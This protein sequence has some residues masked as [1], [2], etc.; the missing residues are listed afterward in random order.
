MKNRTWVMAVALAMAGTQGNCLA[1]SSHAWDD[2]ALPV[3]QR[4]AQLVDAMT[5]Q[6]QISL[7]HPQNGA[8][9][10][11]LGIPLPPS[12]PE[13]MRQ[14]KPAGAIGSAGFVAAMP[15][16]G[17]PSLQESDA[18]L[19]V[20]N[21]GYQ[22]PGDQ[23]TALPSGLALAASF[24]RAMARQVGVALGAEAHA[25][26]FN[27]QLAG[28]INLTRD[29]RGG[30]NFEYAGEDPLLAGLMVGEQVAGIQSR[31]VVSTVKHFALNDQETGRA[32]LDARIDEAALR[33]S[34]LLA[35]QIAI[36]L[37]QPGA[38]MCSY[39][40]INGKYA[41]ENDFLLNHVL[42]G[43]WKFP[44]WVMSDW[45]AAHGLKS[46][47]D[48]GLDQQSPQGGDP[49]YFAG[50]QAAVE[51]GEIP[52][53]R[54]R[55]M[56]Y[57][58]VHSLFVVGAMDDPAQPG[59]FIDKEAHAAL[60][61]KAA[62][63]G[64][65]LLKN[66][67]LLPLASS[68]KS[69]AII[70]G[71]ADVGV[72]SGGGSSQVQPY[73][74]VFRDARG[75]KGV[76][77]F[78]APIYGLSSPLKALQALRPGISIAY[79]D[80]SDPQRAAAVAAKADVALVFA[81]KP[82]IE[83]L[84][85]PDLS[86]PDNQ[87]ILITAV[88]KANP[89]TA[90]VLETG[91]PVAMPWLGQVHAV[92]EAWYPGQRGGEAIAALLDGKV[93]PSGRLPIT[94][95]AA[96]AQL[97][98]SSIPGFDPAKQVPFDMAGKPEPFALDQNEG[99]DV[100]YRWFEKQSATPL[101]P[102]GYGL[103]YTHFDYSHLHVKAGDRL[104]VVFKLRNTGKR[105]GVEVAQLYAAPPGRT[106]RLVGWARVELK[107]GETRTVSI[108]ADPRL[109]A[110]YDL[111]SARWGRAAGSFDV[112]VGTAAGRPQLQGKAALDAAP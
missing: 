65:V 106:H 50:L 22:R 35:F 2:S 20:A 36:E 30:R 15:D 56:A 62:E 41:C 99:S 69:V 47:V 110:S 105:A 26:G 28:G 76:A 42:K 102:F 53:A 98:R 109:L 86:L 5:L 19:G 92:L 71:H 51:K 94:F 11:S 101:F 68:V 81:V 45:G 44:G 89:K 4:A 77:A 80:G 111:A 85:A 32:V 48:A 60:M 91:N 59:G 112:Y 33:E 16:L 64:A 57:R 93:A 87:D 38:V 96:L 23:S 31:H 27:V 70:G 46:S 90:V 54:V 7:L 8:S 3:D 84:D 13:W 75:Q 83:S 72:L 29:P 34:D 6:Q 49:D 10:A 67:G 100:G 73:G 95:P 17:M 66:D 24:D 78:L 55:E 107:P 52:R 104:K 63:A 43:E 82:Q 25:K 79:D 40:K 21:I 12:I 108:A 1:A 14:P 37:G 88:A 103:T 58:I 18:G 61:Q 9:L 39:N 97:P 74:G